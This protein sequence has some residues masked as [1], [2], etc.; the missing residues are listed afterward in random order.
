MKRFL[1]TVLGFLL[2][3]ISSGVTPS[4]LIALNHDSNPPSANL[5]SSSDTLIFAHVIV[6]HGE[7]NIQKTY[8]NDPYKD[9]SFWPGGF[10]QLTKVPNKSLFAFRF[11]PVG[12][13][14]I[15]EPISH[16]NRWGNNNFLNSVGICVVDTIIC[17][18]SDIRRIKCTF[19][20][21]M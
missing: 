19:N 3:E 21:R 18:A 8:P 1:L 2:L 7:R 20:Q 14:L 13:E 11:I 10:G 6:R 9:E 4:T 16:T 15:G 5:D 17:W 12:K